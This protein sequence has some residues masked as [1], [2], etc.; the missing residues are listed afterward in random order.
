[1]P[2]SAG[3]DTSA[4]TSG[5]SALDDWLRL[6]ALKNEQRAASRTFVVVDQDDAVV[7]FYSL[8]AS[9]VALATAPGWRRRNSPDPITVILLGRLA[10]AQEHQGQGLGQAMLQDALRRI[11]GVSA[12][13][14]AQAVLVH[15]IDDTAAAFYRRFGF[16]DS[17][18]ANNLFLPMKLIAAA[19]GL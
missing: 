10:V 13:I 7:G 14:G 3:H 15:A 12:T 11:V 6:R 16:R 8:A 4:F 2:I 17:L 9:S 5:R 18:D 19:A 1:M